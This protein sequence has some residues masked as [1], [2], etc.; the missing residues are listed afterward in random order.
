VD[1]EKIDRQAIKAYLSTLQKPE[2][3]GP[4]HNSIGTCTVL[5]QQ[6]RSS[7]SGYTIQVL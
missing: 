2:E 4:S 3:E 5:L 7:T 6:Y 1:F